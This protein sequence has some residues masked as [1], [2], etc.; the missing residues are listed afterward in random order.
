MN[1]KNQTDRKREREKINAHIDHL[2]NINHDLE[3]KR[4]KSDLEMKL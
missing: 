4:K 3:K 1:N 2:I